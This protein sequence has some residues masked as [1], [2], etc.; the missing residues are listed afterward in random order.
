MST[1]IEKH[2]AHREEMFRLVERYY[3]S[4]FTRRQFSQQEGISQ[5]KLSYWIQRY[6]RHRREHLA[7]E[8]TAKFISLNPASES[9]LQVWDHAPLVELRLGNGMILRIYGSDA[10]C[11]P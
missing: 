11:L 7:Q 2:I 3:K 10:P 4:G 5:S 9:D 8:A 1:S 6:R